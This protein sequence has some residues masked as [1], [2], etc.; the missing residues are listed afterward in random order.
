GQRPAPGDVHAP[1]ARRGGAR[2]PG[3]A[4]RA[5]RPPSQLLRRSALRVRLPRGRHARR[6]R[7]GCAARR[8]R[9]S[10]VGGAVMR[11]S[12][13]YPGRV[14][15]ARND[16]LARRTFRYPVYFAAIDLTE[17]PALDRELRLFSHGGRNLFALHDRDYE[18]GAAGLP[19]ALADLVAANRLPVPHA[20]RL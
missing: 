5:R 12:A 4:P 13:L 17:L 2:G 20:T 6:A 19:G 7:R 8:R 3:R 18:A 9:R 10:P 16:E 11:T 1:A 15:P 14:T